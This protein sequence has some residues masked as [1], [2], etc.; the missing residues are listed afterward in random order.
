MNQLYTVV[1]GTKIEDVVGVVDGLMREGWIPSGGINTVFEID[2]EGKAILTFRQ[3]MCQ[4]P[5]KR[6][7]KPN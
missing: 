6:L 1:T 7:I 2:A 5:S 3:A 4:L